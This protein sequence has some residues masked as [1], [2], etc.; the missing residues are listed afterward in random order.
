[1]QA[2]KFG[3]CLRCFLLLISFFKFLSAC[4]AFVL[5]VA[6]RMS[7]FSLHESKVLAFCASLFEL[8]VSVVSV[9]SKTI[10][11]AM[12]LSSTL[13]FSLFYGILSNQPAVKNGTKLLVHRR[14]PLR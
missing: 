7:T 14:C 11:N 3:Y 4:S 10:I 13:L 2:L 1:M 5:L 8:C 9:Y 6:L 12:N